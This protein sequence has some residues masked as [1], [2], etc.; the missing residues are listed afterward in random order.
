MGVAEVGPAEIC[1]AG[2][3]VVAVVLVV[4]AVDVVAAFI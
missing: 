1:V 3:V 2:A 4:D